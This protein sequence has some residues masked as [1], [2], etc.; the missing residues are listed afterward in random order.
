[1]PAPVTI[2]RPTAYAS[3]TGTWK[4]PVSAASLP[5]STRSYGSPAASAARDDGRDL[6]GHVGRA[7]RD[8]VG[9]DQHPGVRA[10]RE[11]AADLLDRLGDADADDR[12]EPPVAS[13]TWMASSTAQASWSPI[14]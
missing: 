9:L 5:S 8:R 7:E 6:G 4:S 14:V 12:R 11:R 3:R 2:G 1:M 10:E 13:A